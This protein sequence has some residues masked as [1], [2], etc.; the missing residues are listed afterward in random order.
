MLLI[1]A[2]FI[3]SAQFP[4]QE[5]LPEAMDGPEP[6]SAF[7]LSSTTAKA[8]VFLLALLLPILARYNLLSILAHI[9]Y[10]NRADRRIERAGR[11]QHQAHHRVLCHRDLG[12]MTIAL[13][14]NALIAAMLLFI[15]QT[16]YNALLLMCAGAITRANDNEDDIYRIR[17]YPM[18]SPLFIATL[19]GVVSSAIIIPLGGLF[20]ISSIGAAVASNRLVYTVLVMVD[21]A[22]SLYLFKWIFVPMRAGARSATKGIYG[23]L[24]RSGLAAIYLLAALVVIVPFA[25]TYLSKSLGVPGVFA[26]VALNGDAAREGL[27]MLEGFALAW[28][29]YLNV[30]PYN[31]KAHVRL[32]ATLYNS[33]PVNLIYLSFAMVVTAVSNFMHSFDHGLY[34]FT[35]GITRAATRFGSSL[36]LMVDGRTDVYLSAFALG[37]IAAIVLYLVW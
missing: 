2:A 31:M 17:S 37:A 4:F 27:A 22:S 8:G 36:R 34:A 33:V 3:K 18:R 13:G 10:G 5:W 9:R 35:I 23:A 6:A 15:M 19:I 21:F 7:I 32:Y 26:S 12:L 16:F 24:P 14:F 29:L 28:V 30:K 25:Y 11:E 20:A 1:I